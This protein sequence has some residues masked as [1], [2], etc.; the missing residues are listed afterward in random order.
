MSLFQNPNPGCAGECRFE[1]SARSTTLLYYTPIYDKNG[2][3]VNPDANT[4]RWK[5][6]CRACQKAWEAVSKL[7]NTKFTEVTE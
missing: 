5:V 4:S 6:Y 2:V 7:D 3:N 1:E